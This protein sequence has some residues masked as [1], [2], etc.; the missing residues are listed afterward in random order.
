[1]EKV[2]SDYRKKRALEERVKAQ[3]PVAGPGVQSNVFEAVL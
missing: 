2:R 3:Q 1:M